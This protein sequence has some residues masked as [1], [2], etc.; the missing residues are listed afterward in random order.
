MELYFDSSI[1]IKL[2]YA[3]KIDTLKIPSYTRRSVKY[4]RSAAS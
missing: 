2:I 4:N 1:S 3:K